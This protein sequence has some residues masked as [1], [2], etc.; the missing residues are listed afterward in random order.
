M[1]LLCVME[2]NETPTREQ[3]LTAAEANPHGFGFAIMTSDRIL[4]GR[5]MNAEEVIDRFLH[6]RAGFPGGHAMFHTRFTTHGTTTKS[7]CHPF[8][9]A[10]DPD[11]V[12]AHNG[13]LP[14][15]PDDDR[16]DTR[17]FAEEWL[18]EL[19]V[20]SLDDPV[21]FAGL[22]DWARGSKVAIFSKS[23]LLQKDVYILNEHLGHWNNGIWWSNYSY[24]KYKSYGSYCGGLPYRS[25]DRYSEVAAEDSDILLDEDGIESFEDG[26][27]CNFCRQRDIDSDYAMCR[28]CGMCLDCYEDVADCLCYVPEHITKRRATRVRGRAE[29]TWSLG[30]NTDPSQQILPLHW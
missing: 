25:W 13:V 11:I 6:L 18:P 9:V 23:N 30:L 10:G 29:Q 14:L 28:S 3:L 22:E 4:T 24:E 27:N 12:L 16:S 19:G 8:R 17:L 2:P 20:E 26:V 7:N 21:L 5:G 1:C 15:N